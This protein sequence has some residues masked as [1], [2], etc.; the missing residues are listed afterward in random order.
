MGGYFKKDGLSCIAA[1]IFVAKEK[2]T[3]HADICRLKTQMRAEKNLRKSARNKSALIC[4]KKNRQVHADRR[5]LKS[6]DDRI[7]NSQFLNS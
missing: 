2:N 7:R 6:A 1:I 4:E 5:R 3:F